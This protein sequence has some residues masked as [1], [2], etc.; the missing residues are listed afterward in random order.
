LPFE[1]AADLGAK[2]GDPFLKHFLGDDDFFK[3][4]NTDPDAGGNWHPTPA[5]L[6]DITSTGN[7][8]TI[9]ANGDPY[10]A[11]SV[12]SDLMEIN[13]DYGYI[14]SGHVAT[15][16]IFSGAF[17]IS[18]GWYNNGVLQE[19]QDI[20]SFDVADTAGQDF[21]WSGAVPAGLT[22]PDDYASI[23]IVFWSAGL[24]GP[25][26]KDSQVIL[27]DLLFLQTQDYGY[28]SDDHQ[29]I[30][31]YDDIAETWSWADAQDQARMYDITPFSGHDVIAS[32]DKWYFCDASAT[33]VMGS[34]LDPEIIVRGAVRIPEYGTFQSLGGGWGLNGL[35]GENTP[36]YCDLVDP[37]TGINIIFAFWSCG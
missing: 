15:N 22:G 30:C 21:K 1:V 28:V 35:C 18:I 9:K 20:I 19:Q 11:G 33:S 29:W 3:V 4:I 34:T 24:G 5:A 27:S 10:S 37:L 26:Y 32:G 36:F 6:V 13:A 14:L 12:F 16:A 23:H 17:K 7:S 31:E 2:F 8:L 25:L